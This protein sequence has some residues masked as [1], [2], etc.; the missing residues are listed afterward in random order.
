MLVLAFSCGVWPYAD[1]HGLCTSANV[2]QQMLKWSRDE[3]KGRHWTRGWTEVACN[4]FS[5]KVVIQRGV[6]MAVHARPRVG[7]P[8]VGHPWQGLGYPTHTHK[9]FISVM[10]L[11]MDDL[12]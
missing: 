2:A 11:C 9:G 1:M 12:T 5:V 3:P 4:Q 10:H 6:C 7:S 8:S